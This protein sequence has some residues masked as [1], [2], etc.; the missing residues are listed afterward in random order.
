MNSLNQY[1]NEIKQNHS[2]T[3][4]LVKAILFC[5]LFTILLILFSF[6]KSFL[7]AQYERLIHGS[8]GSL[9]AILTTILFLKIDKSTITDSGLSYQKTTIKHFL[10]G[11]LIGLVLMGLLTVSVIL[12]SGFIIELNSKTSFPNFIFWTLP[13]IPLAFMEELGFRGYPLII[14]KKT[15]GIRPSIV[16]SSFLFAC[17]HLANGWTIQNAFLGAGS[18]GMIFGLTAICS[19]GISMSTGL[20]VAANLT[21][22]AF[23]ISDRSYNIWVLKQNNGLSLENYQSSPLEILLPQISLLM[24]GILAMEF[25]LRKKNIA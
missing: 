21:T 6:S 15:F 24:L 3:A 16:M 9:A 10:W 12:A 14:L 20:H 19:K 4:I 25:Y 11:L 18:W 13:L 2:K 23:G 17:Y 8:L 1:L 7:P 5:L 22:S